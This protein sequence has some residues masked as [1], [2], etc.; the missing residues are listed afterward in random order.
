MDE[1]VSIL[2]GTFAACPTGSGEFRI[3]AELPIHFLI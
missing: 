2:G 3:F 1:R